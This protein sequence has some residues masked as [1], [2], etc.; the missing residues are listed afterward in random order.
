MLHWLS[1]VKTGITVYSA[2]ERCANELPMGSFKI[3][4]MVHL[5]RVYIMCTDRI[6]MDT[7]KKDLKAFYIQRKCEWTRTCDY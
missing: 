7:K 2:D 3:A 5:M 4:L 6:L 1:Y